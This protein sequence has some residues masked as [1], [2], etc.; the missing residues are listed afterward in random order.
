MRKTVSALVALGAVLAGS[1]HV[2][3][4]EP[5]RGLATALVYWTGV[6]VTRF[7]RR[8]DDVAKAGGVAALGALAYSVVDAPLAV[9]RRNARLTVGVGPAV[10][11]GGPSVRLG[12][13]IGR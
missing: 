8:T 13:T 9:R 2:Y 10:H 12:M 3:A 11:R 1:G 4:G 5:T 7:G 6:I